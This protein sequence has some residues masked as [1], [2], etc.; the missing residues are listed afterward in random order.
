L[1]TEHVLVALIAGPH[2]IAGR[3]L[4]ELG[5]A[6]SAAQRVRAI[7]ESPGYNR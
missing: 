2:A 5:A 3:V 6:E 7:I 4:H 1:G